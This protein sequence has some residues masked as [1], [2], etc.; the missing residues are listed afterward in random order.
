M[1]L[2]QSIGRLSCNRGEIHCSSK[3]MQQS[4]TTLQLNSLICNAEINDSTTGIVLDGSRK[5]VFDWS[6]VQN[7]IAVSQLAD[8]HTSEIPSVELQVKFALYGYRKVEG[9]WLHY[10]QN[11]SGFNF[12]RRNSRK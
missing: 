9:Y 1:N 3:H 11:S 7:S 4:P 10:E 6:F 2:S 12:P 8:E 5:S